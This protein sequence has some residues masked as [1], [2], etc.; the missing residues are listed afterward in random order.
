MV[1]MRVLTLAVFSFFMLISAHSQVL[2]KLGK[3]LESDARW[4]VRMKA[5]HKMDQALDTVLAQPKKILTKKDSSA[6]QNSQQNQ[7]LQTSENQQQEN[8]GMNASVNSSNDDESQGYVTIGLSA[9]EV[10]GSGTITISGTSVKYGDLSSVKLNITG[11]STTENISAPLNES[12][13]YKKEFTATT[14]GDYIITVFSS[15]NKTKQTAKLKVTEIG[16]M[17]WQENI[18]VTDKALDRLETDVK[19]AEQSISSKDKAQLETKMEEVRDKIKL[20][21][22]LIKDLDDAMGEL[23]GAQVTPNQAKNLSDI[24]DVLSHQRLEMQKMNDKEH[25]PADNTICEYL[26]MINEA[27]AAFQTF[28]NFEGVALKGAIKNILIDKGVPYG[29]EKANN[30]ANVG[31]VTGGLSKFLAKLAANAQFDAQSLETAIGKAGIAADL[32]QFICDVLLKTYCGLF[33]GELAER[34]AIIYRNKNNEVWWSYSYDTKAAVSLRYP[35]SQTGKTIKMKGN[36]EGNATKFT[37]SAN[38]EL[39]DEF[40]KARGKAKAYPVPLVTPVAVPFATS[41]YDILGFGAVARSA[42]TPA[43]FNVAVDA[44]YDVDQG[45]VKLYVN[46]AIDDFTEKVQYIYGYVWIIMGLPKVSVIP[47]PINKVRP[48]LNTVVKEKNEL[49]VTR[50]GKNNLL[51]K[52]E[53]TKKIGEKS[54]IEHVISYT[55]EARNDN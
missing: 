48:T 15:N 26:V 41:Q 7:Q 31:P 16:Q 28:T 2:K 13:Q 47:Y 33:S 35:K 29:V 27:L 12:N 52:G 43:Y 36:I 17:N 23:K 20:A 19:R 44:D 46:Q 9:Y 32:G 54:P 21:N 14:S 53:G 42:A 38:P 25:T 39:M 49:T 50:D 18:L 1:T 10:F 45:T 11:P 37:F 55:L 24:N 8:G 4:K 6:K 40:E 30:V 22:K 3:E 5:N 34:Y 51:I